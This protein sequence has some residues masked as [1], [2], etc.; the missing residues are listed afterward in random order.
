MVPH[1][2]AELVLC[3]SPSVSSMW[4]IF[5]VS[6]W[7]ESHDSHADFPVYDK[8]VC[9]SRVSQTHLSACVEC[10]LYFIYIFMFLLFYPLSF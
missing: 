3:Y 5:A 6:F 9:F 7:I 4:R 2:Q 1:K 10:L 8:L